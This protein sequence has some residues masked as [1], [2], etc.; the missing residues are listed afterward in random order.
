MKKFFKIIF[1]KNLCIII[2][3]LNYV[4]NAHADIL[5]TF[6][7]SPFE[8][9][10]SFWEYNFSYSDII[11]NKNNNEQLSLVD[12]F[13]TNLSYIKQDK[14]TIGFVSSI[15]TNAWSNYKSN[16]Q[17]TN[18]S[19]NVGFFLIKRPYYL[20]GNWNPMIRAS[21]SFMPKSDVE[22]YAGK[23]FIIGGSRANC[24]V[25]GKNFTESKKGNNI[26]PSFQTKG[27][28]FNLGFGLRKVNSKWRSKNTYELLLE[29]SLVDY[30]N[31]YGSGFKNILLSSNPKIPQE[32]NWL[33]HSLK[34]GYYNARKIND[35]WGLGIG[36]TSYYVTTRGYSTVKQSNGT[37]F[38]LDTRLTRNFKERFYLSLGAAITTN[39]TLGYAPLEYN[40]KNE[41][42]FNKLSGN[43]SLSIGLVNNA[44]YSKLDNKKENLEELYE[45]K[46]AND[47]SNQYKEETKNHNH[48][49]KTKKI[50]EFNIDKSLMSYALNYAS[51]YDIIELK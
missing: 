9:N 24:F 29:N 1:L 17:D 2:I 47:F 13:K 7:L 37:N 45:K 44:L 39:H 4:F 48:L 6:D 30:E 18:L 40:Q 50:T 27:S 34:L 41:H 12:K 26:V 38:I 23:T 20:T 32:K 42:L 35:K 16:N 10:I 21:Y 51:S 28:S 5:T 11:N 3:A 31:I 36:I 14:K 25:V 15:D 22:C 19:Y 43:L 49:T 33:V 46:I 8:E